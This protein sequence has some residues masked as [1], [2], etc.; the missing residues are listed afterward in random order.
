M[1]LPAH[2]A[3]L[4]CTVK[5]ARAPCLV[6]SY[7]W[8]VQ[9]GAAG[10]ACAPC[11]VGFGVAVSPVQGGRNCQRSKPCWFGRMDGPVLGGLHCPT[12]MLCR[13]WWMNGPGSGWMAL[14][15]NNV[16]RVPA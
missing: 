11:W 9:F 10:T 12:T 15:A 8:T 1:A 4:V 6:A 7:G 3:M 5:N 2:R 16:E 13:F 14:L